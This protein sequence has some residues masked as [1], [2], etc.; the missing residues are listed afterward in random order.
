MTLK[1]ILE[2]EIM[3]SAEAALEYEA[4]DH[5]AANAAFAGLLAAVIGLKGGK[6]LDLGTGP[7]DL[8]IAI[9]RRILGVKITAVEL[10][11]S[12]LKLAS[13]RIAR[14]G[15]AGR[16][17][18]V[19]ADAKATA[20]PSGAFD[21]VI[22]NNLIHHIADP[23]LIFR[24]IAR[25]CRPGGGILLRDLRRPANRR[26]IS[27]MVARCAGSDTPCQQELLRSSMH[28]SLRVAEVRGYALRAGLADFALK[29]D[30]ERHWQLQRPVR[31]TTGRR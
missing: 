14:A 20:F 3:H 13:K 30:G 15:L 31:G 4:I 26:R 5:T 7:C 1:R 19:K 28:A 21:C 11:P 29:A 12:M 25:L 24:E 16:I 2:P 6:L 10:A 18:L 23:G 9:C 17:S 22:C 8:P 27:A